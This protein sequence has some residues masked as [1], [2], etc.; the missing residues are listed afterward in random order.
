MSNDP[1]F[2]SVKVSA[3]LFFSS[4]LILALSSY[5]SHITLILC[6]VIRIKFYKFQMLTT[7][8]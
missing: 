5:F 1:Y 8:Y 3:H 2:M 7:K 4:P 6:S